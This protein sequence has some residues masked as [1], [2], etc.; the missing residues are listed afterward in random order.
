L[1]GASADQ[2]HDFDNCSSELEPVIQSYIQFRECPIK[3]ISSE[4]GE[5]VLVLNPGEKLTGGG[6]RMGKVQQPMSPG[7]CGSM[8]EETDER[9]VLGNKKVLK[10][11]VVHRLTAEDPGRRRLS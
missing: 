9:R 4:F 7:G 8:A 1:S 2:Q 11:C 10:S 3:R 5:T 6:S